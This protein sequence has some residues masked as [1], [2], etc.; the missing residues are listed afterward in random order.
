MLDVAV[1]IGSYERAGTTRELYNVIGDLLRDAG[2]PAAYF[3]TPVTLDRRFGRVITRFDMPKG[4]TRSYASR[5][6]LADPLPDIALQ[7]GKAL[8]WSEAARLSTLS[9]EEKA[10][11]AHMA[12]LGLVEGVAVPCWGPGGRTGFVAASRPGA[13]RIEDE[14]VATAQTLLQMGFLRYC[15]L[16]ETPNLSEPRLSQRELDVLTWISR[17]K[18][19]TVIGDILGISRETVDSYVRRIFAKLGVSDRTSAVTAAALRGYVYGG[20]FRTRPGQQPTEVPSL[21]ETEEPPSAT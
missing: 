2:L 9:E 8:R 16:I 17:G 4:W 11:L 3:L 5:L 13:A 15:E 19:N 1:I 20:T 18:S 14:E 12:T 21:R 7:S 10:Y 6:H